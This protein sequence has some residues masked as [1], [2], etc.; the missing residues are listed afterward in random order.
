MFSFTF[1]QSRP[2]VST[3]MRLYH[4]LMGMAVRCK[5]LEPPVLMEDCCTRMTTCLVKVTSRNSFTPAP[6]L[7]SVKGLR[8]ECVYP[9][10]TGP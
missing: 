2:R 5:T 4:G 1:H 6:V 9:S 7:M 8:K 10:V 3:E